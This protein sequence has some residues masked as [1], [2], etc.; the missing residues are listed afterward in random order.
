MTDGRIKEP[1]PFCNCP[2]KAIQIKEVAKGLNHIECPNCRATFNWV[3]SK[4]ELIDKWNSRYR[5]A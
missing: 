1:C 4:R 3:G 2:A 5:K